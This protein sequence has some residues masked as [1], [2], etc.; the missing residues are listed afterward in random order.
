MLARIGESVY[1]ENTKIYIRNRRISIYL[2]LKTG[3]FNYIRG[4]FSIIR[5]R[6]LSPS[7]HPPQQNSKILSS[8]TFFGYR[9][10][11]IAEIAS[12]GQFLFL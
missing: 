7:T 8:P 6:I 2:D 12:K 4:H 5:N 11:K 9:C 3:F 10:L 1:V